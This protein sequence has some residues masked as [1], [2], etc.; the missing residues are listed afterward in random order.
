MRKFVTGLFALGLCLAMSIQAFAAPK[1]V[2]GTAIDETIYR[3]YEANWRKFAR[4]AFEVDGTFAY[5]PNYDSRLENSLGMTT[6]Q[7]MDELSKEWEERSGNLVVKKV[8]R[9]P[10]EDAEAMAKALP[11]LRVGAYG[12]V[13]SVEV[14]QVIDRNQMIV[15]EIWLVNRKKLGGAYKRDEEK[16]ARRNNGNVN[17]DDLNFNYASRLKQMALQEDRKAGFTR[18][19]RLIG[20]DTRGLRAGDRWEG[21]NSKGFQV[22]IVR[23]ETPEP[24]K[25]DEPRDR[26]RRGENQPRLVLAELEQSMRETL[27]E[28][29]FKKLLDER[30]MTVVEFVDL[31]RTMRDR[32]RENAE[33]RIHN[34]LLPEEMNED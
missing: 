32:D 14:V 1:E 4:Y 2:D 19:F 27:D 25:D 18:T 10:R 34:S 28:E 21:P 6:S 16:N 17:R 20:F 15:R 22:G 3:G 29:G 26:R 13:D 31:V 23:W 5:I 7:A 8:K 11:E 24:P 30:G 12:W 33:E 9:P